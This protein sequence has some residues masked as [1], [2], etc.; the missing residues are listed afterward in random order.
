MTKLRTIGFASCFVLSACLPSGQAFSQE[1]TYYQG[2]SWTI[3]M[4]KKATGKASSESAYCEV[5]TTSFEPRSVA[6]QFSPSKEAG[7][8]R[9]I[10][11]LRKSGW[12]LPIGATANVQVP[13][14]KAGRDGQI[15]EGPPMTFNVESADTMASLVADYDPSWQIEM[16]NA[17][18][19]GVFV[20]TKY[21]ST[22]WFRFVDG[23]E[24]EWNPASF[25]K[26]EQKT[27]F[28]AYQQCLSDLSQMAADPAQGGSAPLS[29][30]SPLKPQAPHGAQTSSPPID[31]GQRADQAEA[32][33]PSDVWRFTTTEAD[34][35]ETCYVETQKGDSKVGFMGSPGE[36]L[37]GFVEGV[38]KGETRAT[39]HVDDKPAYVS[40][41][42]QNDYSGWHEFDQLPMDLLDQ[43]SNG[44]ELAI[45]GAKG[46]RT[47]VSLKGASE[48][49]SR[50][51]ACFGTAEP[52]LDAATSPA[53]RK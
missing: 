28:N 19:N 48:A 38:F 29:S 14:V 37:I 16:A 39:W 23:N 21:G 35:G 47:V 30:T 45:T 27:A 44:K 2:T 41:G 26:F 4:V 12:Q 20:R 33:A 36:H 22:L 5:K 43:I 32:A 17:L 7:T 6:L 1:T 18:L 15:I 40:D 24:P 8:Y 42:S 49:V 46:E 34:W 52:D 51:K 13:L 25:E 10:I 9:T 31:N 11:K 50:L 3:Q 53:Q